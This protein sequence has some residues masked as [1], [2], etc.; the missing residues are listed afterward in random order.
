MSVSNKYES[1][2]HEGIVES[3]DDRSL[4]VKIISDSACSGCHAEGFCL[5][6]GQK[7]KDIVIPGKYFVSPGD[8]VKVLMKKSMGYKALFLGYILPFIVFMAALIILV[9]FSVGELYAGL[10]ALAVL[11]PY[12]LTL[13]FFRKRIE[14]KFTFTIKA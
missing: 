8:S 11:I 4:K 6:S 1:I 12:Y 10:G 13:W 5:I 14:N 3:A 7:E 2:E 9:I